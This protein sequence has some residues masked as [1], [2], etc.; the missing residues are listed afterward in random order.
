MCLRGGQ[1]AALF[2]D[3]EIQAVFGCNPRATLADYAAQE[4]DVQGFWGGSKEDDARTFIPAKIR[5]KGESEW[6]DVDCA[7]MHG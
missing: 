6:K 4:V 1:P 2:A 7:T 5:K 3:N